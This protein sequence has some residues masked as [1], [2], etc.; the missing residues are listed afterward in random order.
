MEF[1]ELYPDRVTKDR[2]GIYR[3]SVEVNMNRD[4]STRDQFKTAIIIVCVSVLVLNLIL[5][6]MVG[7]FSFAWIPF[8][9]CGFVML[10][11]VPIFKLYKKTLRDHFVVGYEMN[12]EA[13]LTVWDLAMQR[14]M[15]N[16]A[17]ITAALGVASGHPMQGLGYGM[18]A[19]AAAQ[20]V[21]TKFQSIRNI[22]EVR[23]ESRIELKM[24][25]SPRSVWL[26]PEDYDMVLDFIRKRVSDAEHHWN[27][28]Y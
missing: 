2:D 13:I 1:S 15:D 5:M 18:S 10:I 27:P 3:W 6:A 22:K 4:H 7:D 24:L 20:P 8:A 28:S 19:S 17:L 16:V 21:L 26:P 9:C 12:D 14:Q 23:K 25:P 11:S